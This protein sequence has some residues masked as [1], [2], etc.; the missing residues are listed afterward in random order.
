MW[1]DISIVF[2]RHYR[3]FSGSLSIQ[4]ATFAA[5]AIIGG[6]AIPI[7]LLTG[8]ISRFA[9]FSN[10]I[11]LSGFLICI[12]FAGI[13]SAESFYSERVHYTLQAVLSS[14]LR[15]VCLF[16]GKWLWFMFA[17][18]V[19]LFVTTLVSRVV[20]LL[21]VGSSWGSSEEYWFTVVMFLFTL[22]SASWVIA[23]NSILSLMIR[24]PKAA[25]MLGSIANLVPFLLGLILIRVLGLDFN[26]KALMIIGGICLLLAIVS[27]IAA[28]QA[29]R[30]EYVRL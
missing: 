30:S 20:V 16:V 6:V 10:F 5:L 25:Q 17:V 8:D 1:T 14:P 13:I 4:L 22:S 21:W 12:F 3:A 27:F 15:P 11:D 18:T 23:A 29:F 7:A 26:V 24:D 9:S 19:L 2:W 28:L